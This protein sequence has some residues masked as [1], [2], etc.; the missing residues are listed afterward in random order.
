MRLDGSRT[1]LAWIAVVAV[2]PPMTCIAADAPAAS[3]APAA[4]TARASVEQIEDGLALLRIGSLSGGLLGR[5]RRRG[6]HWLRVSGQTLA[7][8]CLL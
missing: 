6:G 8:C 3:A 4:P 5:R 2:L 1:V 7:L